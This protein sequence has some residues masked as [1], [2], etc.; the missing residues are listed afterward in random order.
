M[1]QFLVIKYRKKEAKNHFLPDH[2]DLVWLRLAHFPPLVCCQEKY[3]STD[4]LT[5]RHFLS[6]IRS[7]GSFSCFRS[8]LLP[9]LPHDKIRTLAIWLSYL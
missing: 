1:A 2:K 6:P 7:N 5:F 3:L 9:I 4:Y 8:E